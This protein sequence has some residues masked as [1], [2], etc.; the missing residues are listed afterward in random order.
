MKNKESLIPEEWFNR[1]D[2]DL[3]VAKFGRDRKFGCICK[4][5]GVKVMLIQF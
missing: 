4:E 1:A 2:K 3:E 5:S